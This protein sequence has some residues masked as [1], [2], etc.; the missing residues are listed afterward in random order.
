MGDSMNAYYKTKIGVIQLT[1]EKDI[2]LRIDIVEE[3]GH[4]NK[5]NTF[6]NNIFTQIEE[7]LDGKRKKFENINIKLQGT[8]FQLRV[9][10]KISQIPYGELLSYKDIAILIGNGNAS[11]AVGKALNKNPIPIIIPCH[12]V[13][14]RK[15]NL[16]GF[17]YGIEL[18]KVLIE[19]E[20]K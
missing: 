10:N 18:K 8:E 14:G 2:L 3:V 12:R 6:T 17:A 7:Y 19:L 5:K 4:E 13:I 16:T 11:R 1:Y 9:W 20:K 15:G